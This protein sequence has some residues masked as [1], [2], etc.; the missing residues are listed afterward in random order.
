MTTLDGS[1][2]DRFP[3][4]LR[5]EAT[6]LSIVSSV[7]ETDL[8]NFSVPANIMG[9]SRALRCTICYTRLNNSGAA[10]TAPTFRVA[11]DG[12]TRFQDA[13][14]AAAASANW[15]AGYIEFMLA[16]QNASNTMILSGFLRQ[17]VNTAP[18]TGI[19]DIAGSADFGGA[20]G[21]ATGTTFTQAT[22]AAWN[23][24]VSWQNGTNAATVEFRRHYLLLE[25]L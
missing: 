13:S 23:L 22:N 11:V 6:L 20:F 18:T 16:M 3:L 24:R 1:P 21:S 5:S 4:I 15:V 17:S 2:A 7:T 10:E 25:L 8:L 19:G 14:N 12:T 9:I